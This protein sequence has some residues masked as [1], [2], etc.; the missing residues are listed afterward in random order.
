MAGWIMGMQMMGAKRRFRLVAVSLLLA[1]A[2]PVLAQ[3]YTSPKPVLVAAAA[4][5]QS[6]LTELVPLFER[7]H[8]ARVSL[9]LGSSATL[10]RQIQQGLP[11]EL[12]LSADEDFVFR[13]AD[14][15]LTQDRGVVYATGRLVLLVPSGSRLVLDP[16]LSGLKAGLSEVRKFAIA[17]P[18]LAPYGKAAVQVLQMQALWP[19]LQ[20]RLVL[21]DNI[22]QTTQFVSTGA[23]E[24]GITAL[25]L[26]LAPEVAARTRF[27][28][29]SDAL[30]G[31]VRQR[32]VLLKNA[33]PGARAFHDFL[34]SPDAKAV[35][36][37]YGFR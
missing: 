22:A 6:A 11:A 36:A 17:N 35:L 27:V 16:G 2:G 15:G 23:A 28:L 14:A 9:T 3:A 33:G 10:V 1:L 4:N 34:Q 31:P 25:S 32:M 21:G 19:G 20:G 24:A 18:E 13:L 29:I 12:F 30:H 26:A 8:R 5:M 37:R 7:G